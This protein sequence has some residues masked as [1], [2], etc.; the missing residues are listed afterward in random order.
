MRVGIADDHTVVRDGIRWMLADA[1]GIEIVGEAADGHD[2]VA[3]LRTLD[4]D[5]LVLDLRMGGTSGFDV[6]DTARRERLDTRVL[7]MS[8]H[9]EPSHVRRALKMGAC[10][11]VLKNSGRDELLRA[12]DAVAAGNRYVQGDLA[13]VLIDEEARAEIA[14]R[15]REILVLVADGAENK[16]IAR[17]LGLSQETVKSYLRNLFA[18]WDV[19][20]RAEAVAMGIRLGVIE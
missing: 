11:Y 10:G 18:R 9:D 14:P 1:E 17:E 12:I 16:Q 5:I 7:V 13:A 15:E 19:S 2:A 8:M 3:L 6:L 20:S 4:P